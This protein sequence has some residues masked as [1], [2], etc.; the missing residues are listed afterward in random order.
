MPRKEGIAQTIWMSVAIPGM[1]AGKLGCPAEL[2][3]GERYKTTGD[4]TTDAARVA[5]HHGPPVIA[6]GHLD[7]QFMRHFVLQLVKRA[8]GLHHDGRV[9]LLACC[10]QS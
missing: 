9:A 10:H 3:L 5:G 4:L 1:L 8:G 7:S 2:L 6:F